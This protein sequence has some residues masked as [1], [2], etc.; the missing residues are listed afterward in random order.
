MELR[1]K[2]KLQI[3]AKLIYDKKPGALIGEKESFFVEWFWGKW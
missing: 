1:Y 2:S 3:Y